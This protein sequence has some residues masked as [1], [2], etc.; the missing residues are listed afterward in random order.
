MEP[1]AHV[2]TD[3]EANLVGKK[4]SYLRDLYSC[5]M[6]IGCDSAA[7]AS[8]HRQC[9]LGRHP[10]GFHALPESFS[11]IMLTGCSGA[12]PTFFWTSCLR[13]WI[14]FRASAIKHPL[15]A[16]IEIA[17]HGRFLIGIITSLAWN[18][19]PSRETQ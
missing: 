3:V 14:R 1:Q 4:M 18:H 2:C 8:A 12:A 19:E 17:R 16:R 10:V 7:P 6:E 11:G 13:N 5:L 15:G 9:I